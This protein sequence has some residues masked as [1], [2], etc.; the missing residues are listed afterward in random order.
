LKKAGG[1][2][3]DGQLQLALETLDIILKV[4]YENIRARR[5]RSETL[6]KLA[7][8]DMCL[9]SRNVWIHYQEEDEQFL[10]QGQSEG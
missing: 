8:T 5:L 10:K 6:K 3:A 1:L 7:E 2:V 4:D 9:M